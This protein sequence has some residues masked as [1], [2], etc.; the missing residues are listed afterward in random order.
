MTDK[1]IVSSIPLTYNTGLHGT[2]SSI[3]TGKIANVGLIH[4]FDMITIQFAYFNEAGIQINKSA[5]NI[6]GAD[7]INDLWMQIEP[8][9][10]APVSKA[11]DTINEYYTGFRIIASESWRNNV[12]DWILTDDIPAV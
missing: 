7:N 11:Q 1:K 4:G 3:I 8:L 10:P 2:E 9:L 6:E 5:F 12:S